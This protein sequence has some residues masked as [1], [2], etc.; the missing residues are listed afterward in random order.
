MQGGKARCQA[1]LKSDQMARQTISVL[2]SVFI[3]EA[4]LVL[5]SDRD[6]MLVGVTD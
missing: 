3:S 2:E 4:R 1:V 5:P 6:G